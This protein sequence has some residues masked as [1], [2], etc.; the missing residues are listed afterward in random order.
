MDDYVVHWIAKTSQGNPGFICV[1]MEFRKLDLNIVPLLK[2]I[3]ADGSDPADVWVLYK[4]V[5]IYDAMKAFRYLL[6]WS[7]D[8]K[9]TLHAYVQ[10]PLN[11]WWTV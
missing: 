8:K 4:D 2:G 3:E 9:E 7:E 5:C 11:T 1:F 10:R 6:K